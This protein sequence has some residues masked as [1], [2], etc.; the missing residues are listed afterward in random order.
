MND[1]EKQEAAKTREFVVNAYLKGHL[2]HEEYVLVMSKMLEKQK[3]QG[4]R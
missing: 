2:T 4:L 3:A 1:K